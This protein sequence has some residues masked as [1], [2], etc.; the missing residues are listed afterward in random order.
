MN[1]T[2][3][4]ARARLLSLLTVVRFVSPRQALNVGTE[5]SQLGCV[6]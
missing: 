2:W 5:V 4:I 3:G 6:N 1:G